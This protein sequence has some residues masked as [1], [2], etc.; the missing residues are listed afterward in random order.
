MQVTGQGRGRE[1]AGLGSAGG[2]RQDSRHV[3]GQALQSGKNKE[4]ENSGL[5]VLL[6]G[7]LG[8]W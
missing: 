7:L 4:W 3:G 2:S 8:V 1:S 5:L 6:L